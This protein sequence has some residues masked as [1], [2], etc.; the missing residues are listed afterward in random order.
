MH[1]RGLP[2]PYSLLRAV[3]VGSSLERKHEMGRILSVKTQSSSL[4]TERTS[5]SVVGKWYPS[6]V[7]SKLTEGD[8]VSLRLTL[9]TVQ[10]SS[11]RLETFGSASRHLSETQARPLRRPILPMNRRVQ[12]K[13]KVVEDDRHLFASSLILNDY[14]HREAVPKCHRADVVQ[15]IS[16]VPQ[17]G[18]LIFQMSLFAYG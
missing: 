2:L 15:T 18:K 9:L 12:E 1:A 8:L 17:V 10:K 5:C 14:H 13:V 7:K 6:L 16:Q 4:K 11:N 3:E